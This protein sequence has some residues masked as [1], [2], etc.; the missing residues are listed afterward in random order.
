MKIHQF[1]YALFLLALILVGITSLVYSQEAPEQ[2]NGELNPVEQTIEIPN[3]LESQVTKLEKKVTDLQLSH[4]ALIDSL[5][6]PSQIYTMVFGAAILLVFAVVMFFVMRMIRRLRNEVDTSERLLKDRFNNSEQRWEGQLKH[7]RQQSKDSTQKLEEIV[8]NYSTI[9]NEQK[10]LQNIL[11]K[12][13]NR[14]DGLDLTLVNLDLDKVLDKTVIEQPQ[15][16]DQL[17]LEEIIQEAR[18]KVESLARTYENGEPIDWIDVEDPTPSQIT[19]QILNW[20]AR[21]IEDWKDDLE[22]SGTAN[23]DLIQT[24]GYA[25]QAIKDKLKEIRGPAPPVPESPEVETDVNTDAAYNEFQNECTAYVSRYEGLLI[26]FQLGCTIDEKEYDQFIPQFVK[27]R[28]FNS[29]A[30]FI[31]FDQLP[32]QLDE[33]LQLVGYEVV[34]IEI[35]KTRAD[36]RMHEVQDSRQTNAEPGTVV[37]VVL[38]GLQRIDDGEIIQKPVVIRGE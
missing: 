16:D 29:V 32:E 17:Q 8:S 36:A 7:I 31:K 37:E 14:L 13:G 27:D 19:L 2:S 34:P 9:R 26:G 1:R 20:I 3:P 5:D 15:V 10:N 18:A 6:N 12:L 4:D 33:Y 22:Q 11:S 23:P 38:P 21:S 24:L 28:L 35:G 30:R 25:N